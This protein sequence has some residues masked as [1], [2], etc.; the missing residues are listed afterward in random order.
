MLF[1]YVATVRA[2]EPPNGTNQQALQSHRARQAIAGPVHH[3]SNDVGNR[4]QR[5]AAPR[6]RLADR[7]L[8]HHGHAQG[9]ACGPEPPTSWAEGYPDSIAV[10]GHQTSAGYHSDPANMA[11]TVPANSWAT[12]VNPE[13]DSICQRILIHNPGIRGH[14]VNLYDVDAN[15]GDAA[16]MVTHATEMTPRPDLVV[17]QVIDYDMNCP[18]FADDF[19]QMESRLVSSL[20]VLQQR[21]PQTRVF[22][23]SQFGSPTTAVQALDPAAIAWRSLQDAGYLPRG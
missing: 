22:M 9:C 5:S 1:V 7:G 17:M 20:Q 15:N 19:A 2:C 12:G 14:N 4:P 3:Q 18:A 13:V 11:A 8:P 16:S 23:V 21:A 10:I 6:R